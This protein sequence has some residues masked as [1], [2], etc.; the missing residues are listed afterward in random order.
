M[1]PISQTWLPT[2]PYADTMGVPK[3]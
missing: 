1:D 3:W 2:H